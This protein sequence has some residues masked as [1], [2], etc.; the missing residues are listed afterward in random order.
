MTR[1][2]IA[3]CC[4]AVLVVAAPLAVLAQDAGEHNPADLEKAFP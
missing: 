1:R 2:P 4:L 3:R